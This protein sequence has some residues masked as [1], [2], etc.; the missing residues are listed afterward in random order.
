MTINNL[1]L[2]F[3]NVSPFVAN[4]TLPRWSST[5]HHQMAGDVNRLKAK[6]LR[7]ATRWQETPIHGIESHV[8][9]ED[10]YRMPLIEI[11]R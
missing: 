5:D 11:P 4:V 6:V 10:M 3:S 1:V 9:A 7:T 2:Y 8:C